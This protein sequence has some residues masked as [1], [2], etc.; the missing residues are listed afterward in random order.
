ML[1]NDISRPPPPRH[2]PLCLLQTF[3]LL[4]GPH[5][6]GMLHRGLSLLARP[7]V[8]FQSQSLLRKRLLLSLLEALQEERMTPKWNGFFYDAK[9]IEDH[10]LGG[11]RKKRLFGNCTT[12]AIGPLD[13]TEE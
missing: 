13:L 1:L 2:V 3:S 7:L 11:K 9:S 8:C 4:C 12:E 10:I 5:P 6:Q